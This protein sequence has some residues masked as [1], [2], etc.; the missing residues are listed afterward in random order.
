MEESI[1]FYELNYLSYSYRFISITASKNGVTSLKL[2][3]DNS[4]DS[5]R[6][7]LEES[8]FIKSAY[9]ELEEYFLKERRTFECKLDIV[10]TSFQKR[11][12]QALIN[13]EYGKV[14]T[15]SELAELS[16]LS[17][18][19]AR[20]VGSAVRLNPVAI[21]IP[22]HR[23]IGSSDLARKSVGNYFFG[24]TVKRELLALE[25]VELE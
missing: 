24:S 7:K 6:F 2:R 22:C 4:F 15:Y 18:R 8:D 25:G 10:G 13:L 3:K 23:V 9:N 14:I 21:I 17:K 20:A 11:V 5:K 1:Y 16:G 19:Y 12:W